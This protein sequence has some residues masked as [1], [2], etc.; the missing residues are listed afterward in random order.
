MVFPARE[1]GDSPNESSCVLV[2]TLN[3]RGHE[4]GRMDG[5][6]PEEY[7]RDA[8]YN[9]QPNSDPISCNH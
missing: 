1:A 2:E 4:L 9:F 3:Q 8:K 5:L 7:D 6:N